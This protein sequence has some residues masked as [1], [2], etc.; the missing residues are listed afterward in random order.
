MNAS[1]STYFVMSY[2]PTVFTELNMMVVRLSGATSLR[3]SKCP[4]LLAQWMSSSPL[5]RAHFTEAA[6]HA[7]LPVVHKTK[8][9]A[10]CT[11]ADATFPTPYLIGLLLELGAPRSC[12]R[13]LSEYINRRGPLTPPTPGCPSHGLSPHGT[14]L[15]QR[16]SH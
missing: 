7:P 16:G 1:L 15:T 5:I 10:I 4:D 9:Q 11:Y 6:D 14:N 13:V 2:P 3:D 12:F 8:V